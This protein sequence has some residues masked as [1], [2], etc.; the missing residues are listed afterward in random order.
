LI[1]WRLDRHVVASLFV[2]PWI[3]QQPP[4]ARIRILVLVAWLAALAGLPRIASAQCSAQQTAELLAS[5]GVPPDSFGFSVSISGDVAVIG[6]F[7][8]KT[9]SGLTEAGAAYVFRLVGS[10]WVQ[11][12]ELTASDEAASDSFG[13]CVSISG[14]VIIAGSPNAHNAA[15]VRT[16]AAY[17]FRFDGASWVEEQKLLASDG[18]KSDQFGH[19]LSMDGDAL[20]VGTVDIAVPPLERRPMSS[21][22]RVETGSKS[23]S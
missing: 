12:Q 19:S 14:N 8:K 13:Y 20:V 11:E 22:K 3:P 2:A 21:V 4:A 18:K 16:G 15:G 1:V 9:P 10:S 17:V 5:D 6:A 7:R 23:K